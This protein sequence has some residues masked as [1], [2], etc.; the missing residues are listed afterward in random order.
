MMNGV[1]AEVG[2]VNSGSGTIGALDGTKKGRSLSEGGN[3][4]A[5]DL[6]SLNVEFR[7]RSPFSGDRAPLRKWMLCR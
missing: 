3:D 1:A 7:T 5:Q 2:G 4:S 6:I